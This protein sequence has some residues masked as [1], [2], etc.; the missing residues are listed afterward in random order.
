MP[1]ATEHLRT[2]LDLSRKSWKAILAETDDDH[3]WIPNPNQQ[4]AIPGL[5]V[6]PLMVDAWLRSIDEADAILAGTKLVPSWIAGPPGNP[7]GLNVS[8]I[9]TRPPPTFDLILWIQGI[10]TD[11]YLQSGALTD[12]KVWRRLKEVFGANLCYYAL[13]FN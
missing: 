3:E 5:V 8:L 11:P 2:A 10:G 1:K 9:F 7:S 4:G 6:N 12:A 13:W